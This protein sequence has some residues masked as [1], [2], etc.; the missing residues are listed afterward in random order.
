MSSFALLTL[1]ALTELQHIQCTNS[2]PVQSPPKESIHFCRAEYSKLRGVRWKVGP[3]KGWVWRTP[4]F[5]SSPPLFWVLGFAASVYFLSMETVCSIGMKTSFLPYWIQTQPGLL[6]NCNTFSVNAVLEWNENIL[7]K[8][9]STL[10]RTVHCYQLPR[11]CVGRS[12]SKAVK[13]NIPFKV[14][15]ATWRWQWALP[16]NSTSPLPIY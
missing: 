9:M 10:S 8:Q 15:N 13:I 3:T 16:V 4:Y 1:V 14:K 11:G 12:G 6:R 5:S 2:V 7:V